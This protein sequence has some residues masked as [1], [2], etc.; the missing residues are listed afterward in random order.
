MECTRCGAALP[1]DTAT[2]PACGAKV[3]VAPVTAVAGACIADRFHLVRPL[4]RGG[5]GEVWLAEDRHLDGALVA[6]KLL[7][8]SL[9]NDRRA[10]AD[11]KREVLLARRLRHPNILAVHTFWDTPGC[12]FVVMEYVAGQNLDQA[13]GDRNRP[14]TLDE[15]LPW[16]QQLANALDYAHGEGVLHRDVKPANFLLDEQGVLRLADFGIA[17]TV[18]ELSREKGG[19]ITCGTLLFMSPEQLA[20]AMLDA[21]S[22]LYSLAASAY[23]LLAGAP[24]FYMGPVI[25]QIQMKEPPPIAH[26]PPAVN[27]ALLRGLAKDR[28]LRPTSCGA[29]FRALASATQYAGAGAAL[30]GDDAAGRP[31]MVRAA[32]D[33]E[34]V[35]LTLRRPPI[36]RGR[37]GSLLMQSG[38]V[39]REQL[40]Q[41]FARQRETHERLG[42]ALMALGFVDDAAIARAVAR[43]LRLPFVDLDTEP[44]HPE[45]ARIVSQGVAERRKCLPLRYEGE[46]LV[47]AMADPLDINTLNEL[48]ASAGQRVNVVVAAESQLRAAVARLYAGIV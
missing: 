24:P 41:A 36:E 11:L 21:R 34:T 35:V 47:V 46:G 15:V 32:R 18:R 29:F 3:A 9:L 4:G 13:L 42:S 25:T 31:R 14:F 39:S 40:E 26:M 30:P 22:D 16:L 2:C 38:A 12:R 44:V 48:E 37:L 45:A 10:L 33:T 43:Q 20:G 7:R 17:R 6:C 27:N 5:L 8:E 23:E 28:N 1:A 19:E